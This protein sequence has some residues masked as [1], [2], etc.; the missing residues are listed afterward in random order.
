ML[1]KF[2][3]LVE[4][5]AE[6]GAYEQLSPNEN[7]PK[8]KSDPPQSSRK[9]TDEYTK[10]TNWVINYESILSPGGEPTWM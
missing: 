6:A 4:H 5:T 2:I 10:F 9:C 8:F 3:V 7:D 1:G